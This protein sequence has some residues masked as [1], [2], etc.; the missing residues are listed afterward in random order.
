MTPYTLEQ[1]IQCVKRE[2]VL[3]K[4]VYPRWVMDHKMK[5]EQ[6]L[7]EI[8]AMEAVLETLKR[9]EPIANNIDYFLPIFPS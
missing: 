5:E 3:R 2:I 7:R 1:Q 9:L 8:G 6:A 4:R